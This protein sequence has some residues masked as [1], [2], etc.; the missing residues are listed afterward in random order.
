MTHTAGYDYNPYGQDVEGFF[1]K[2]PITSQ[3]VLNRIAKI[4]LQHEPGEKFTYGFSTDIA[5]YLAE[6]IGGKPLDVLMRERVLDPLGMNDTYFVLPPD[7]YNRLVTMY[8][9]DTQTGH[10]KIY[11]DELAQNFP[12]IDYRTA[13]CGGGG[14]VGTIGDYARFCQMILNGGEFNGKRIL[15]RK[16]VELMSSDQMEGV[17]SYLKFGL[18]FELT[19]KHR[20]NKCM[21]P[22]NSLKW[23]GAFGTDY[24]IDRK[25]NMILLLYT[26]IQ[27]SYE[28]NVDTQDRFHIS[29]YQSMK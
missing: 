19:D 14:L 15:G 25:N 17:S 4:P 22:E 23:G 10:Y 1:Y 16:T 24:I 8:M 11:P 18:G 27:Q 7:R 29:V 20:Y 3:D 12:K 9:R 28:E 21:V 2:Y 6:V 5:G 26:N 13:F